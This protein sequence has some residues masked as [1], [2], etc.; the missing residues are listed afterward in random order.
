MNLIHSLLFKLCC[1]ILSSLA[2]GYSGS[3]LDILVYCKRKKRGDK[4]Q[5]SVHIDH[6]YYYATGYLGNRKKENI[7]AGF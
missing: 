6:F 1:Y 5:C 3:K 2:F 4:V 7:I